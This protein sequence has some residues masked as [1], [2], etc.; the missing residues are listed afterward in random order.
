MLIYAIFQ[1]AK[2]FINQTQNVDDIYFKIYLK[3]MVAYALQKLEHVLQ[4]LLL[5]LKRKAF[6]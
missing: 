6:L 3:N 1:Y 4:K 5:P 2:D